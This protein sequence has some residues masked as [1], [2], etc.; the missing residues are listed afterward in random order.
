MTDVARQQLHQGIID[1]FRAN[2]GQVAQFTDRNLL[3]LTT[4]GART[5][6]PRTW[7]LAY[8][9]RGDDV[10]IFAANG[11]RPHRPG[12]YFN[13]IATPTA[14]IEVG[15]ES[16]PVSA[17][18]ATAET[19]P[20]IWHDIVDSS[21]AVADSITQFQSQVPWE[22]PLITLTRSADSH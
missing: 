17:T 14:T 10:V 16:W 1:E 21:P 11:G 18:V 6:E 8:I 19:R 15:T 3:L 22:I 9:R 12:W 13:L 7:P 20:Q 2:G 5:G 4:I